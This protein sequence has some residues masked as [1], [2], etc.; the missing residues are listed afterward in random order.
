MA[1]LRVQGLV[2]MI[3]LLA[4]TGVVSAQNVQTSGEGVSIHGFIDATAFLQNQNFTFGNGQNA[5]FPVP[6][7]TKTDRWFLD[8]DVR[9]TRLT[10]GFNP[11]KLDDN[12]K[13]AAT[14]EADFFG[15]FNGT[16][17]FSNAQATPRL[18]LA[19]VDLIRGKTTYRVGQG[20]APL[21]GNVPASYSHLAFPIGYGATGFVGWRFPGVFIYHDMTPAGSAVSS[22]FTFAVMRNTWSAP[23]NIID[24]GSA[25]PAST[26]PQVEGRF[27]WSGKTRTGTWGT[28]VVGH[29]DKKDLSGAGTKSAKDSLSA[30]AGEVGAKVASG[31]FSV[32]GNAYTG[33]AI[34][35]Q[36]GQ[37][38]Q[39]GDIKS[40][41]LW[42]QGGYAFNKKWSGYLFYGMEKPNKDNVIAAKATRVKEQLLVP[43]LMFN[44]GSYGFNVEWLHS[45]L[46]TAAATGVETGTKGDQL[47]ASVIYK[48]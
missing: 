9:N 27:D 11:T 16:G 29:W 46:T 5:E 38:S 17:G 8:G 45:K 43:S 34:G 31:A 44:L 39:F 4:W 10:L 2:L 26:L 30:W 33:K 23:G 47:A 15:G 7:E 24:S 14:L 48:F 41:G 42:A 21:F 40:W 22:K 32:Q 1:R 36:F 3:F 19:F 12:N 13:V 37:I 6:P 28:Y 18:R 35:Q 20:W 25:G